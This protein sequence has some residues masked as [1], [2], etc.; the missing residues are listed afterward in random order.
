MRKR[1][2]IY[3]CAESQITLSCSPFLDFICGHASRKLQQTIFEIF[4]FDWRNIPRVGDGGYIFVDLLG[5]DRCP[6][7]KNQQMGTFQYLWLSGSFFINFL[8]HLWI[9][10]DHYLERL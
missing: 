6:S 7:T 3:R 2:G 8:T 9:F 10:N 5:L 4:Q 1:G